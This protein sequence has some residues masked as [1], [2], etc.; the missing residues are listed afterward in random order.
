MIEQNSRVSHTD[1]LPQN[2]R[3]NAMPVL[4]LTKPHSLLKFT[5]KKKKT[6]NNPKT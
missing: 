1:E 3:D 4:L 5:G 2:T 6:T